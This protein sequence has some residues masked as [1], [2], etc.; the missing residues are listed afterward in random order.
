MAAAVM[1]RRRKR[2]LA[3]ITDATQGFL[4][5][6][7]AFGGDLYADF[8]R[9]RFSMPPFRTVVPM[10]AAVREDGWILDFG[11]GPGHAS[12]VIAK[13]AAPERLVC[14]DLSFTSL[15]LAK[16]FFVPEANFVCVDADAPL[17]FEDGFFSTVFRTV[18]TSS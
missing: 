10:A 14:A 6:V 8:M 18:T 7:K 3:R 17:P 1:L 13:L 4:E 2:L 15:V 5:A 9:H 16:H 11:C 12:F